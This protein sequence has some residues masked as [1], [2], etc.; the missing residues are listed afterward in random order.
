M[1]T[2][3]EYIESIGTISPNIF[4]EGKKIDDVTIH[5]FLKPIV[6]NIGETYALLNS[7]IPMSMFM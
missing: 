7:P 5:P 6:E 2:K 4:Y 3:Q 1:K